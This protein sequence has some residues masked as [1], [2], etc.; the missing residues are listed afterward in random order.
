MDE[1]E[2][3]E[4]HFSQ[5]LVY[6]KLST[7]HLVD[8]CFVSET[9]RSWWTAKC[10]QEKTGWHHVYSSARMKLASWNESAKSKLLSIGMDTRM[11]GI[12]P[13]FGG[14]ENVA[15]LL[16]AGCSFHPINPLNRN[17]MRNFLIKSSKMYSMQ[18]IKNIYNNFAKAVYKSNVR[19]IRNV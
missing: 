18:T 19:S 12:S 8:S 9:I 13:W 11:D 17:R 16:F 6:V 4:Y 5:E 3:I 2:K 1:N 15:S 10:V 7:I 14:C